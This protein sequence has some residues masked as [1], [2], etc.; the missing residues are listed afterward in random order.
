MVVGLRDTCHGA[1]AL[2]LRP[3]NTYV[4]SEDVNK[5]DGSVVRR[6]ADLTTSMSD[7]KCLVE[8]IRLNS[9]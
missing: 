1:T 5:A 3:V 6:F 4:Q 8:L 2:V 9:R 7:N